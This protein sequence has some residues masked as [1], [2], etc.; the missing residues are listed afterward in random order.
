MKRVLFDVNV[1]LDVLFDRAPHAE[2]SAAAWAV[3]ESGA[4]EGL[5]AAHAVTTIYYLVRKELGALK[6]GQTIG[7]MLDIF[8]G[9]SCKTRQPA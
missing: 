9:G 2:A 6:A 7:S 5:L 1:I 8:A 3:G 4:A